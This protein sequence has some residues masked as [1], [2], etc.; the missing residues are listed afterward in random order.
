MH[1]DD[2]HS[3]LLQ[4]IDLSLLIFV[5]TLSLFPL[6]LSLECCLLLVDLHVGVQGW[7]IVFPQTYCQVVLLRDRNWQFSCIF[8]YYRH[9]I[10]SLASSWEDLQSWGRLRV[11]RTFRNDVV[12]RPS[13]YHWDSCSLS[14]IQDE[15]LQSYRV[16]L[17]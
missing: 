10:L 14:W 9:A 7:N 5:L 12:R 4:T 8:D 15:I 16:H 6:N 2:D 17:C 11:S 3:I 13:P 1:H